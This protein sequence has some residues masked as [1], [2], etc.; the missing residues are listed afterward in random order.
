MAHRTLPKHIQ[1][2]LLVFFAAN[3]VHFTHNA[4]Y[5]AYYPG[6]PSSFTREKIYMAWIAG[7]SVGLL[8]LLAYRAKFKIL[9]L[10]LLAAYGAVGI[11]GL[12]HYTLAL[13][14]EHTLATNLTIWFEVL[15]GLSLLLS[16]AV[17][18]GKTLSMRLQQ[19]ARSPRIV[20]H[21]VGL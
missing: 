14:S 10:A 19:G 12:A 1:V 17:L 9:G 8:G 20:P 18:I 15:T 3:L 7:A 21:L 11:D 6:M 4:E 5:I 2:L 13:C 16:S